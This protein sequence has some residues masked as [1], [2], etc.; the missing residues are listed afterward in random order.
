MNISDID[1]QDKNENE[2]SDNNHNRKNDTKENINDVDE[3]NEEEEDNEDNVRALTYEEIR[4]RN[5]AR[6]EEFLNYL[7]PQGMIQSERQKNGLEKKK[8]S[9]INQSHLN[10]MNIHELC[11]Y[12]QQKLPARPTE[13]MRILEYLQQVSCLTLKFLWKPMN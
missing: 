1:I 12:L 9:H 3:G 11:N 2:E 13:V 6:N 7:F 8:N 10:Q 4:Q 5:I